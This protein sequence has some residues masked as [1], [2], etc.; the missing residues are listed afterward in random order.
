MKL[1]HRIG[2]ALAQWLVASFIVVVGTFHPDL[3]Q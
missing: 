2:A 1:R 3:K